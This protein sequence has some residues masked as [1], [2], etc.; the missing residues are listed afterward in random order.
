MTFDFHSKTIVR[1]FGILLLALGVAST[2]CASKKRFSGLG[3]LTPGE[4]YEEGRR[5]LEL[6]KTAEALEAFQT[7]DFR[8]AGAERQALEPLVKLGIADATFY[9]DTV[10]AYIDARQL[11]LDFV[12]LYGDHPRAPYAQFQAGVCALAQANQPTKDQSQTHAAFADL[13]EVGQRY[14]GS[15][16][17]DAASDMIRRAEGRLAQHEYLVGM[18]YFKRKHFFAAADRFRGILEHHPRYD[19]MP[20]VYLRLGEALLRLDDDVEARVYLG[21]LINDYPE[22]TYVKRAELL[23]NP[24]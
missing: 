3:G 21:K 6:R 12:T 11:Y 8:F 14:P 24:N 15:P 10:L 20:K 13:Y 23:L 22:S 4:A 5:L 17:A 19:E 16:Y 2:G 9:Q 7:I 18:F 1:L